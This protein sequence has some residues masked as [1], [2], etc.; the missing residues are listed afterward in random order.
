M[1]TTQGCQNCQLLYSTL[2]L[3]KLQECV[4]STVNTY[5]PMMSKPHTP[6]LSHL[7]F[8]IFKIIVSM[9]LILIF[10]ISYI[11]V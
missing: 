4:Q 9:P 10:F 11:I 2:I 6:V 8:V 7:P 1:L 5:I 3:Q